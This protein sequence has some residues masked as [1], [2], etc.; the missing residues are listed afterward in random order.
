[1]KGFTLIE[2]LVVLAL[3]VIIIGYSAPFMIKFLAQTDVRSERNTTVSLLRE[4]RSKAITNQ[5]DDSWGLHITATD[6]T[7]FK[8]TSYSARD[9][10]F[11]KTYPRSKGVTIT[12]LTDGIF[13]RMSGTSSSATIIISNATATYTVS[14][15]NEGQIN[16]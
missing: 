1:M 12:G 7:T 9:T 2:L 5:N 16:W 15:N 13:A 4:S 6:F 11:D 10:A 14:I 3:F 8:G